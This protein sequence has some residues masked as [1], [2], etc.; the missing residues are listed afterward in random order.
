VNWI[1]TQNY[2]A[3]SA[4]SGFPTSKLSKLHGNIFTE[5]CSKCSR[6]YHRDYEVPLDDSVDHETVLTVVVI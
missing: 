1:A 4:R 6:V 3:L 5:T 2:D